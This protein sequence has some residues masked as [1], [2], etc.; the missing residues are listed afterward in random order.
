MSLLETEIN[1]TKYMLQKKK[2][3]KKNHLHIFNRMNIYYVFQT[4]NH[5][6]QINALIKLCYINSSQSRSKH[7][8][9]TF[10]RVWMILPTAKWKIKKCLRSYFLLSKHLNLISNLQKREFRKKRK[11]LTSRFNL[12]AST[13]FV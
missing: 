3:I 4:Y 9:L 8:F 10:W 12:T 11:S 2:K 1:S 13:V 7:I 6:L 5:I